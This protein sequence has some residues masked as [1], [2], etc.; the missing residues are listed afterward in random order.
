V[1]PSRRI[2]NRVILNF[3]IF[4]ISFFLQ[5]ACH[6]SYIFVTDRFFYESSLLGEFLIF[7]K[8]NENDGP[9][10][11]IPQQHVIITVK[12]E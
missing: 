11:V 12:H 3:G 2:F 4:E 8:F 5:I 1:I 6:L 7:L 9:F 10:F